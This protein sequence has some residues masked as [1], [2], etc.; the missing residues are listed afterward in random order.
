MPPKHSIRGQQAHEDEANASAPLTDDDRYLLMLA[1]EVRACAES[2]RNIVLCP[3]TQEHV[4]RFGS[5]DAHKR[6]ER[7]RMERMLRAWRGIRDEDGAPYRDA[8]MLLTSWVL[9]YADSIRSIHEREG[10]GVTPPSPPELDG[11]RLS[12]YAEQVAGLVAEH[13]PSLAARMVEPER[14]R[15]LRSAI[16]SA[17]TSKRR[18]WRLIA[19][20]WDGIEAGPRDVETWRQDWVRHTKRS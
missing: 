6:L 14:M 2:A 13:Y 19:T 5:V 3:D 20:I 18:P 9:F 10:R 15:R 11:Q 17:A 8:R 4:T 1:D 12:V 16:A 7:E